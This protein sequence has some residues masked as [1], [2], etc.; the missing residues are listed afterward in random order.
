MN[1][2]IQPLNIKNLLSLDRYRIPIYQRKYDWGE[3]E[4][5]Q[6]LEDIADYAS[7]NKD[8]KYYI[9]SL[10]VFA[11]YDR[12]NEY[13]ETIDGQQRLTTLTILMTV[14]CSIDEIK[15][16]MN[17]F[18]KVNLSYDHRNEADEAIR[19]LLDGRFSEHASVASISE[20]YKILK[21][22]LRPTLKSKKLELTAF[23]EYLLAN[24]IIMRIPVP[25]DTELNHY[26]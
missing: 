23:V 14:L 19:L 8:K 13:Y 6:L 12:E 20:V 26:F 21:K 2:N 3:K 4:S 25:Q 16:K 11:R 18:K 9:G 1:N 7:T 10:I 15:H 17:W 22:N 5:L 24:V